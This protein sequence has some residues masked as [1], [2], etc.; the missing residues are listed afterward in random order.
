[1]IT[2]TQDAD[3]LRPK[4]FWIWVIGPTTVVT[5]AFSPFLLKGRMR[6]VTA[7]RLE[8]A[9]QKWHQARINNYEMEVEVSGSQNGVYQITV[10]DGDFQSMTR[11][12]RQA[13]P[14]EGEYWTVDGLFHTIS[15]ELQLPDRTVGGPHASGARRTLQASFD[16]HAGYPLKFLVS[17]S[18][19]SV[20]IQ[21]HRLVVQ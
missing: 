5:L 9:R 10:R 17:G 4:R 14:H 7:Q 6:P 13:N 3:K 12:G 19:R 21:V 8:A 15:E 20:Q 18:T 16:H 1:M 11:D 2:L